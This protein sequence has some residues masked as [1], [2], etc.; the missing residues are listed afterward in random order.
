MSSTVSQS[1]RVKGQKTELELTQSVR[2][3]YLQFIGR[4]LI[5]R[6]LKKSFQIVFRTQENRAAPQ[7]KNPLFHAWKSMKKRVSTPE[8]IRTS[9][10]RFRRP[11]LY[12]IELQVR[13]CGEMKTSTTTNIS[14]PTFIVK[15]R[16]QLECSRAIF[17][18]E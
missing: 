10:L 18:K 5:G 11:M 9:N 14:V 13:I 8:R 16:L 7:K 4:K 6:L 3:N 1:A 17:S 15:C 12:P 2:T